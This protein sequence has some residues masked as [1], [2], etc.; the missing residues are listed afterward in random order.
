MKSV[1]ILSDYIHR[2]AIFK[3]VMFI[4]FYIIQLYQIDYLDSF[5]FVLNFP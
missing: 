5:L 1:S 4:E 2:V 3:A